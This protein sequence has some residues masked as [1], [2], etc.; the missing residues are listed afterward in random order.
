MLCEPVGKS[1]P[2]TGFAEGR[3]ASVGGFVEVLIGAL[4]E[5]VNPLPPGGVETLLGGE[6]TGFFSQAHKSTAAMTAET[7][8]IYFI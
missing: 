6:T 4:I 1:L 7:A 8:N 2:V 3:L 5:P